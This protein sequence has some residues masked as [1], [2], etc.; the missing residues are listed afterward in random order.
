MKGKL[1]TYNLLETYFL[2]LHWGC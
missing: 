1:F 2:H